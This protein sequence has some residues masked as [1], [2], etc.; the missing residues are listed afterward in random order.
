MK[1][2]ETDKTDL[3]SR[4]KDF[5]QDN[6]SELKIIREFRKQYSSKKALWWYTRDS[7][8]YRMLNK[9]LRTQDINMIFLFQFFIQDLHQQIT[10]YQCQYP[11][12]VY[13][14]QMMSHDEL[15]SLK[16]SVGCCISILSLLSTGVDRNRALSYVNG[17]DNSNDLCQMIFEID[18]DP[19][20]VRTRPFADISMH[21]FFSGEREVLFV[22]GSVFRITSAQQSD[23]Q[24]WIVQ[25]T[26]CGDDDPGLKSCFEEME[27]KYGYYDGETAFFSFSR[28]LRAMQKF[29]E[30]EKY[31][32][33][34]LQHFSPNDSLLGILYDELA[35]IASNKNDHELSDQWHQKA[36]K[37]KKKTGFSFGN[38]T[39]AGSYNSELH[40]RLSK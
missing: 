30:A 1:P 29:D 37:I 7:F 33:R 3:I 11:I 39:E 23:N 22:M 32:H 25:M 10:K 16:Q 40:N 6:K 27:K 34:L 2:S 38:N 36:I 18:A 21:S 13:R 14:A 24:M 28:V 5:C 12:R 20:V 31:C 19:K 26:L 17:S 9:A 8:I 15:N 4:C 35:E